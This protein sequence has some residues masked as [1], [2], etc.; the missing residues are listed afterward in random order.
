MTL[1]IKRLFKCS[2]RC[3]RISLVLLLE[4]NIHY[5]V[6]YETYQANDLNDHYES[7]FTMMCSNLFIQKDPAVKMK[8][9]VETFLDALSD[10]LILSKVLTRLP[11]G[12]FVIDNTNTIAVWNKKAEQITGISR[13]MIGHPCYDFFKRLLDSEGQKLCPAICPHS[14]ED[15]KPLNQR[16]VGFFKHRDGYR[17]AITIEGIALTNDEGQSFGTMFVFASESE[18]A[19]NAHMIKK[20]YN[21]ANIDPLTGIPKRHYVQSFLVGGIASHRQTQRPY[22]VLFIDING[23][24]HF[25][26]TYDHGAGDEVLKAF[27]EHLQEQTRANDCCGRWGGDEFIVI[28]SLDDQQ[29]SDDQALYRIASR[30]KNVADELVVEYNEIKLS[31]NISIGITKLRDE[32]DLDRVIMRAD[33][34]MY[35]AK[36]H[37]SGHIV[38]DENCHDYEQ[39]LK[40]HS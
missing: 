34:Y 11:F 18:R 2:K 37:A 1:I 9:T 33:S 16:T 25:N 36:R 39:V 12:I 13:E 6:S 19:Y 31:I 14:K 29:R 3:V 24:G 35:M 40:M 4:K 23:F 7:A 10:P 22:A 27:G 38:T 26:N 28:L 15:C 17:I 21:T 8:S 20:L 30:F 32:D 5:A